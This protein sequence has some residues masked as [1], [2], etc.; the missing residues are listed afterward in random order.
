M[1]A[2]P[3]PGDMGRKYITVKLSPNECSS[4]KQMQLT[5]KAAP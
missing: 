3:D 1:G 4:T 5:L 2:M